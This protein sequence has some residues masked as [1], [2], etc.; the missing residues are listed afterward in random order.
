MRNL[1][2]PMLNDRVVF[3]GIAKA[4]SY[5]YKARL[6]KARSNVN[7]R[8][9][10]Y[11]IH[12][13]DLQILPLSNIDVFCADALVKCYSSRT[14]LLDSLRD[15]LLYPDVD[16]FDECPL[17]GIG[18]PSTLDHYLPKE[19]FPEFSIFSKNL[20][21]ICSPCN[22]SYKGVKWIDNGKRIFIHA[23]FDIFPDQT[24][25]ALN[26]SVGA[27]LSLVFNAIQ[28]PE[29]IDFSQ[30]FSSHFEKLN[31]NDRYRRKAAS[32]IARKKRRLEVI[33]RK[34][35]SPADVANALLK[36]ALDLRAEYSHNH[37]KPVL[38]DALARSADF[39]NGGFRKPIAT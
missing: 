5:R 3:S 21:P 11:M 26:I 4:K 17:C 10:E 32:E 7:A 37:W 2:A 15:K 31:L 29:H 1:P 28:L 19:E 39:C 24:F 14:K 9:K 33:F 12:K 25:F 13:A 36:E 34:S 20:I 18:E 23:Y 27:K 16:D 35:G 30:L 22:S 8:Y 6:Y 38:Y